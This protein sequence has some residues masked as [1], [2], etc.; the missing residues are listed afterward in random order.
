MHDDFMFGAVMVDSEKFR[1]RTLGSYVA[2]YM[3]RYSAEQRRGKRK[4]AVSESEFGEYD[5]FADTLPEQMSS[6]QNA[7]GRPGSAYKDRVFRMLLKD[8]KVALEVYNAM[9]NSNYTNPDELEFTTLEN[10]VYMGMK[11]DVSFIIDSQ[12][13]LYE[14][15]S[16]INYNMPLRDLLYVACIYASLVKNKNIY[17]SARI[18]LPEPK[19]IVFYNGTKK[20][21]EQSVYHLSDAYKKKTGDI[22]LD[23]IVQVINI[24]TGF[25]E[26]LKT[27]SPT[28]CQYMQFV[29]CVR[30]YQKSYPLD[31][32]LEYA[33]DDCI[34][35]QILTDFLR[36]NRAEVLHT[37]LFAYDQEEHIRMEKE[38]SLE[39][40]LEKGL[41]KGIDRINK[42]NSCLIEANRQGDLL[43]ATQDREFQ[44]KL[45]KEYGI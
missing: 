1:C 38:E 21:E 39:E 14:H 32:A 20:M 31:E 8:R 41:E 6:A 9:N 24:N 44:K 29:D 30:N 36:K 10:A 4:I 17:G 33:I 18:S 23:L 35:N 26:E 13:V 11:N 37:V 27:K 34:R 22:A 15:Q 25:N 43:R 5:E 40:G 2:E 28:L 3:E 12:L 19:F 7:L 45:L 42:L 16:T